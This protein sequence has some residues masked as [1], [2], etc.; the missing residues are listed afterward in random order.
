MAWMGLGGTS[1]LIPPAILTL[2][3]NTQVL[4]ERRNWSTFPDSANM[5]S[6]AMELC[7]QLLKGVGTGARLIP[8]SDSWGNMLGQSAFIQKQSKMLN[9]DTELWARLCSLANPVPVRGIKVYP[10]GHAEIFTLHKP[11]GYPAG[12]P[13]GNDRGKVVSWGSGENLLPWCVLQPDASLPPDSLQAIQSFLDQNKVDGQA[14]PICPSQITGTFL[15][16]ADMTVWKLRGA[17]NAGFS[18]FLYLNEVENGLQPVPPFDQCNLLP[19]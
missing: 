3:A 12:A 4:G 9:G 16:S 5:L 8:P 10:D 1:K 7:G 18:V 13:V 17:I 19:K 15:A 6:T 11:D 2:V 14:L